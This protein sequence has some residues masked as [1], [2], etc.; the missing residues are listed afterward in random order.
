MGLVRLPFSTGLAN[1]MESARGAYFPKAVAQDA[2][3][4]GVAPAHG[5]MWIKFNEVVTP[6]TVAGER[7][8]TVGVS[9]SDI[10]RNKGFQ[11][12]ADL[13][14]LQLQGR[15]G[16]FHIHV[17]GS[18]LSANNVVVGIY[19]G[20]SRTPE[21]DLDPGVAGPDPSD[22]IS[23]SEVYVTMPSSARPTPFSV[24]ALVTLNYLDRVYLMVQNR[25][26][27]ADITVEFMHTV[28]T[29]VD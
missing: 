13:N 29:R 14:A 3:F 6:V 4:G 1:P 10:T 17:T 15:S 21:W 28:I 2:P 18:V 19:I 27:T 26:G 22:R 24:Q 20:V 16:L 9:D 12:L 23:E 7:Y 5:V 8:A 25:N 11:H